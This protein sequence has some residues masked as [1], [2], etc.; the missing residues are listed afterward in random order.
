MIKNYLIKLYKKLTRPKYILGKGVSIV[1]PNKN[2]NDEV[3]IA[4]D[5]KGSDRP[6]NEAF[7]RRLKNRRA[8]AKEK[9]IIK[10]LEK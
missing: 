1:I 3:L 4:W 2:P 6:I 9:L 5:F 10:E 7:I 8:E